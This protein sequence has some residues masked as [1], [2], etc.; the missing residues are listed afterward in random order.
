[1]VRIAFKALK[2]DAQLPRRAQDTDAGWDLR[3]P[4][5]EHIILSPGK[6]QIVG[7]GF[8]SAIPVGYCMHLLPRSSTQQFVSHGIM[9]AGYRGEWKVRLH[10]PTKDIVSFGGGH[11]IAQVM[12]E[13][14]IE[15]EWYEVDELPASERGEGGFGS[16][17]R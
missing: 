1:M 15:Q 16:T 10:N 14:V 6:W 4:I 5:N 2:D 8:A 13:Q 17:D 11:K 9:D 3:I 7:L 12:L